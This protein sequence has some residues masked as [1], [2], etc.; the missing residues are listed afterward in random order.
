MG[1]GLGLIGVVYQALTN[2]VTNTEYLSVGQSNIRMSLTR[3][4]LI[5]VGCMGC[6]RLG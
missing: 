5:R 2:R 4:D 1:E 3:S 6:M